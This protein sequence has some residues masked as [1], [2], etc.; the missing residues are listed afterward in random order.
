[1]D[2]GEWLKSAPA[3]ILVSIAAGTILWKTARWT[4][5]VDGAAKSW[6]AVSEELR[7]AVKEIQN[8]IKRIFLSL[9][10]RTVVSG[11]PMR[12][13]EFGED[14]AEKVQAK[15]WAAELAPS[16]LSEVEGLP[17]F[18]VDEFSDRYV[19]NSLTDETK[20]R[21]ASCAYEAGIKREGVLDVLRV[22]L[23]DELLSPRAPE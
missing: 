19:R 3:W 6:L 17:P 22:V 18:K 14:I 2:A 8:D 4:M 16:L 20:A 23:R 15:S 7:V 13:T 21:V 5:K 11:S 9:E 10:P 12:L 1:M